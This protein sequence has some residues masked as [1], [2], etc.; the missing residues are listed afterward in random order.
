MVLLLSLVWW[1]RM[2]FSCKPFYG[3]TFHLSQIEI[4]GP[5]AFDK[6]ITVETMKR[7]MIMK[8]IYHHYNDFTWTLQFLISIWLFAAQ[9]VREWNP[10]ATARS[11]TTSYV[12][13]HGPLA[14]YVKLR[15]AH[16]PRIP[17]TVGHR[18]EQA[19]RHVRA[20]RAWWMPVTLTSGFFWSWWRGN[21]S[22]IRGAYATRNFTYLVRGP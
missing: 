8:C 4:Y 1:S 17:A 14:R 22:C 15:D 3:W 9:F 7:N 19:S 10:S 11:E 21:V 5:G 12:S 6:K 13:C 18:S 20:A 16:A 2:G